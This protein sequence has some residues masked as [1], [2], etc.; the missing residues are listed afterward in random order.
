MDINYNKISE[1]YGKSMLENIK[2]NFD[3]VTNNIRYLIKLNFTDVEDIFERYVP[4]F[5]N[6]EEIFKNKINEL[7]KKIGI[8]YV[9]E[10]ENNLDIL[11]EL[12]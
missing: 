7:I 10:I 2:E 11:E 12:V 4:I 5:L 1:I 6:D 9:E 8:N 3:I